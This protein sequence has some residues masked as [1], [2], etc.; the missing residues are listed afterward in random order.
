MG[1]EGD[2][3]E[4]GETG[5]KGKEGPPGNPGL[6]GI[7][8]SD[9]RNQ[10]PPHTLNQVDYCSQLLTLV[11]KSVIW[12]QYVDLTHYANCDWVVVVINQFD[13]I[14]TNSMKNDRTITQINSLRIAA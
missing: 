12:L 13:L 11:N 14:T 7:T 1:H 6:I 9:K 3:G 2:K 4:K 5:M 10:T 8:V